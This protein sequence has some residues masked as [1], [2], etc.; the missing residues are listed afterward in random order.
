VFWNFVLDPGLTATRYVRAIEI[1]P[2]QNRLA[3]HANV[4]IDRFGSRRNKPAGFPGMDFVLDRNPLDPESHFLF[5]KP[6]SVPY[7]EPDGLA[8]RLDPGNLLILNAHLQPSGKPEQV[9]PQVGLY[10]TDNGPRVS[11]S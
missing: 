5:W 3:H 1:H 10:F 6:G 4:L 9:Q 11:R 8:W 2:G 7:S